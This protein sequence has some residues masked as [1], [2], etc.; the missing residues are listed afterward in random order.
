MRKSLILFS[1]LTSLLTA[2]IKNFSLFDIS[3]KNEVKCAS[4]NLS[5]NNISLF[6]NN[7]MTIFKFLIFKTNNRS[8]NFYNSNCS[9]LI[10]I[11]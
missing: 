10:L 11:I 4:V 7:K 2:Q 3:D 8:F 5:I 6:L 9:N 1:A